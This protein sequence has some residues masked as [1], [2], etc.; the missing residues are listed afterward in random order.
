MSA[1]GTAPN[2]DTMEGDD[3]FDT[4]SGTESL[5]REYDEDD[6]DDNSDSSFGARKKRRYMHRILP[7]TEICTRGARRPRF[8]FERRTH[9]KILLASPRK[10]SPKKYKIHTKTDTPEV[11]LTTLHTLWSLSHHFRWT[12]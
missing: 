6:D 1:E 11:Q 12:S 3:D 7:P 9:Q 8:T 2:G 10:D 4:S 5:K